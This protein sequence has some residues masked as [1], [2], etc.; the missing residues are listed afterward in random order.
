V[1]A[2]RELEVVRRERNFLA[3]SMREV[4]GMLEDVRGQKLVPS[5]E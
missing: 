5:K 4:Q 1:Q 2:Q 3:E